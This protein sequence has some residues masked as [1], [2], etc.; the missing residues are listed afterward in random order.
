[1]LS[2]PARRRGLK[3]ALSSLHCYRRSVAS[4]AEAWVETHDQRNELH[5]GNVASR[6]EAWVETLLAG[7]EEEWRCRRLPRG[8]VG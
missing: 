6:A 4:R 3:H 8:G 2:P 1:M 7:N 5:G